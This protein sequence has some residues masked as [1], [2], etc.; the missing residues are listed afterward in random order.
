RE[1][2]ARPRCPTCRAATIR[3]DDA[4]ADQREAAVVCDVSELG[5]GLYVFNRF[6]ANTLLLVEFERAPV[7]PRVIC[8]RH[9]TEVEDGVIL[10][11]K[12]YN[13]FKSTE[14]ETLQRPEE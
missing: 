14:L 2:R 7:K 10:G 3:P 9:A 6:P 12:V 11:G 5:L 1:H 4:K 13:A 8:V